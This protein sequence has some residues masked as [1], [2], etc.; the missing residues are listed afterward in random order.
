MDN[1]IFK[2]LDDVR[3]VGEGVKRL[4]RGSFFLV[5]RRMEGGGGECFLIR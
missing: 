1:Q 3:K 4:S 5:G 2:G